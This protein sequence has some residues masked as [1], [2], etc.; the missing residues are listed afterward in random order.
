[1]DLDTGL[2]SPTVIVPAARATPAQAQA[3]NRARLLGSLA[4]TQQALTR[5]WGQVAAMSGWSP[6]EA[7]QLA[8]L[9]ADLGALAVGA[10]AGGSASGGSSLSPAELQ[11]LD[12]LS[13]T[14]IELVRRKLGSS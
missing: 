5:Q 4:S 11:R 1:M 13:D 14:L 10:P 8:R 7:A 9:R 2:P 3:A 6:D 12:R